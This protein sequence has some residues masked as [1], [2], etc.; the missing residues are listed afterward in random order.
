MNTQAL[1]AGSF[2]PFTIGHWS[3]VDRALRIFD[4]VIIAI[5]ENADKN[6]F[7]P[8]EKRLD[9]IRS[10]YKENARVAVI[11]YSGLT[12]DTARHTGC[13][14]LLR[15]VRSS[16]DFEYERTLS[17]ANRNISGLET[18]L[19]YTLPEYAFVS[20]SL[21]RDLMRHGHSVEQFLPHIH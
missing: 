5:G 17:D 4:R 14:H 1:Y 10:V 13:T 12:A 11:S 8:L 18:V 19:L 21:V 6:A 15:G 7:W 2:D 9:H 20:S 3:V 16:V